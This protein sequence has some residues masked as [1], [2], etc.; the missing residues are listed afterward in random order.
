M[1][2]TAA[3]AYD[4]SG[5]SRLGHSYNTINVSLPVSYIHEQNV[6]SQDIAPGDVL[7]FSDPA[8]APTSTNFAP[9]S[10]D[11]VTAN[12]DLTAADPVFAGISTTAATLQVEGGAEQTIASK[13][14][15]VAHVWTAADTHPG[16]I[17]VVYTE[18]RGL[19]PAG[20]RDNALF[21][22]RGHHTEFTG[23]DSG[24]HALRVVPLRVASASIRNN[25]GTFD[26]FQRLMASCV[27][28][29]IAPAT[30]DT[31]VE[32]LLAM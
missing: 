12:A 17:M 30:K 5:P 23:S 22:G 16:D 18:P 31:Q 32:V 9:L 14:T 28:T 26:G 4:A 19:A 8:K 11:N 2:A 7:V 13:V 21:A 3:R 25:K 10:Q 24:R 15:G 1:F 29:A 27:G 20:R 6:G